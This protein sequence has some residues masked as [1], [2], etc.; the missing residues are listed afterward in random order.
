MTH[1]CGEC[2]KLHNELPRAIMWRLPEDASGKVLA[3]RLD[4]KSMCRTPGHCFVHCEVEVPIIGVPDGRLAFICWVEVTAQEYER[5]LAYRSAEDAPAYEAWVPGKLANPV[6][7]V[8]GTYGAVVEFEV[9]KRDP[10]PYVRRVEPDGPL[11]R[12]LAT[13]V[14]QAVWHKLVGA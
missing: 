11:A 5:L 10:T 9:L 12:C 14:T 7:A 1:K 8:E 6:T 2:G 3:A 13:G 4:G